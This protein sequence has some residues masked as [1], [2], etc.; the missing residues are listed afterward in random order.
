[1]GIKIFTDKKDDEY[2][3]IKDFLD[4][5]YSSYPNDITIGVYESGYIIDNLKKNSFKEENIIIQKMNTEKSISTLDRLLKNEIGRYD[6]VL[7]L[8]PKMLYPSQSI[9]D[10]NENALQEYIDD[11][12]QEVSVS[13]ILF[14]QKDGLLFTVDGHHR[15]LAALNTG[16]YVTCSFTKNNEKIPAL[17]NI[18]KTDI[19]DFEE[20]GHFRYEKYPWNYLEKPQKD[21]IIESNTEKRGEKDGEKHI[22]YRDDFDR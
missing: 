22:D 1:M 2:E 8:N 17:H 9:R 3:L 18:S 19:Y 4:E 15:Q 13:S 11:Y 7:L 12:K 16:N 21:I 14:T 5:K 10:L 6:H 20:V